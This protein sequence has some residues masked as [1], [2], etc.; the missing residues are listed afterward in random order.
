MTTSD[1]KSLHLSNL[2]GKEVNVTDTSGKGILKISGILNLGLSPYKEFVLILDEQ[3]VYSV[4]GKDVTKIEGNEI[5]V[6]HSF[7]PARFFG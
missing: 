6:E 7:L 5:I 3:V 2:L 1:L 4:D